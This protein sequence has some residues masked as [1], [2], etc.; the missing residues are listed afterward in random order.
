MKKFFTV[1]LVGS[2]MSLGACAGNQNADYSY[3]QQAPFA[4][5]RT[6]GAQEVVV[7]RPAPR[8]VEQVFEATQRK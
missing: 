3:E 2:A 4:E 1:L 6:V 5:D 8:R 7:T